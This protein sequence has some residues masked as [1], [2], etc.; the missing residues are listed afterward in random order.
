M[1]QNSNSSIWLALIGVGLWAFSRR[2]APG[3]NLKLTGQPGP[4]GL[5]QQLAY[6]D[7]V[8]YPEDP[9]QSL[10]WGGGHYEPGAPT[11]LGPPIQGEPGSPVERSTDAY[12]IGML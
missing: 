9:G 7:A 4:G 2:S 1:A 6:S 10:V 11:Y 3:P 5:S 8:P 12:T